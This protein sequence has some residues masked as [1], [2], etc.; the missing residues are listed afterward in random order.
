MQR[1]AVA[2]GCSDL[3]SIRAVTGDIGGSSYPHLDRIHQF[4]MDL[5]EPAQL[6]GQLCERR[7]A[8]DFERERGIL[9]HRG[10]PIRL[11]WSWLH[12]R[13]SRQIDNS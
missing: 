1:H 5:G 13:H 6:L 9:E 7:L 11:L 2:G 10:N 12:Q 8:R 3:T 4:A